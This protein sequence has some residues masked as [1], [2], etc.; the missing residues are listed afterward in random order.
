MVGAAVGAAVAGW[1][2]R[3]GQPA[4]RPRRGECVAVASVADS[5][6]DG[7][8][9]TEGADGRD[10]GP[11][12]EDGRPTPWRCEAHELQGITRRTPSPRVYGP[13][14]AA[15]CTVSLAGHCRETDRGQ[16]RMAQV[17]VRCGGGVVA[18]TPGDLLCDAGAGAEA[19]LSFTAAE[20]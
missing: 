11:S 20:Q 10:L 15:L 19:E 16:L 6:S 1:A 7:P 17:F 3:R 5:S 9:H 12:V 4:L 8:G 14:H 13:R 2:A 18:V